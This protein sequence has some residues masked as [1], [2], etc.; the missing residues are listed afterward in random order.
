[1]KLEIDWFA[2]NPYPERCYIHDNDGG[3]FIG[4]PFLY[5]HT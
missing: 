4:I 1:M 3:E 2:R 5:M